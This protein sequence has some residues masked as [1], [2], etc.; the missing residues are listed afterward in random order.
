MK[1]MRILTP[2]LAP[3]ALAV[4]TDALAGPSGYIPAPPPPKTQ[5][6]IV[7]IGASYIHP[8]SEQVSFVDDS[9]QYFDAFR[10]TIDP[11]D[12]WG[13]N[14]SGVWKPHDHFGFEL[15]YVDGDDHVGGNSKGFVTVAGFDD[16]AL[17]N[18]AKFEADMSMAYVNW[19]P[20]DP[21]C[22]FQ[23]YV[24]VGINYTDFGGESF[25]GVARADLNDLGLTSRLSL[26]NS[27]GYTWQIGADINFG[28]DSAWL[29]NM[30]AIYVDSETDLGF[31][32]RNNT[33]TNTDF[34]LESYSGDYLYNPWVF[35]LSI[36]YK[37]DF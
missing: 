32:V 11:D 6:F 17:R 16:V 5:E 1:M 20:L 34:F 28:H 21:S 33:S 18:L 36:G 4:S 8:N 29:V 12:E 27:W 23:P 7:R 37:F 24:G 25:R 26:G 10:A 35:N 19:Y 31:T 30:A 3:L 22:I 9:L 13:W 15:M 2:V 14:I